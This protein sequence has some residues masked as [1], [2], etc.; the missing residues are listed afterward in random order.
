MQQFRRV[1]RGLCG[2]RFDHKRGCGLR[3]FGGAREERRCLRLFRAREHSGDG[4]ALDLLVRD[5]PLPARVSPMPFQPHR[6][7]R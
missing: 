7:A 6:Y 5:R 3:R 1:G 2:G 4:T